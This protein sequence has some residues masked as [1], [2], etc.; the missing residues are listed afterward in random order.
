MPD[1]LTD[2]PDYAFAG[3]EN[4]ENIEFSEI[5]LTIGEK[6][7]AGCTS[8]TNLRLP[9][10]ITNIGIRAFSGCASLT[11]LDFK[12]ESLKLAEGCFENCI[13]IPWIIMV[14]VTEIGDMAFSGCKNLQWIDINWQTN[15]I[16]SKAFAGC[17]SLHD[18]YL[19][20]DIPPV[21]TINTFDTFTENNATLFV[22]QGMRDRYA[23]ATYW[24]RFMTVVMTDDFPCDV[25]GPISEMGNIII[26]DGILTINDL[27]YPIYIYDFSGRLIQIVNLPGSLILPKGMS[28]I[29]YAGKTYKIVH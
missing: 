2:I 13:S 23:M 8:I 22:Q 26:S 11:K 6:S 3:C 17:D 14:G 16:G 25:D 21:I 4:L 29:H 15:R 19:H 1:D 10:S 27:I 28:I 18:I 9:R 5:L 12:F 7:F 24:S 20:P